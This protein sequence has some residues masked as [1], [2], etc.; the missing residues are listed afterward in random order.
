MCGLKLREKSSRSSK[1]ALSKQKHKIYG[2]KTGLYK[3]PV[4][5]DRRRQG[6]RKGGS[7]GGGREGPREEGG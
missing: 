7:E 6:R 2:A 3:K 4:L 5:E 1:S